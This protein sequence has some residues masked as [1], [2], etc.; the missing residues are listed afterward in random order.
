MADILNDAIDFTNLVPNGPRIN[1]TLRLQGNPSG[2]WIQRCVLKITMQLTRGPGALVP[3]DYRA[4]SEVMD[5]VRLLYSGHNIQISGRNL[6]IINSFR[7]AKL[8][9]SNRTL[10]GGDDS[11]VLYIPVEFTPILT[12]KGEKA[13]RVSTEELADAPIE[14]ELINPF[15]A[16]DVDVI[17][18][19]VEL[20]TD[21]A[22]RGSAE[23]IPGG[24]QLYDQTDFQG[25]VLNFNDEQL[26]TVLLGRRTSDNPSVIAN[27]GSIDG[28]GDG[29]YMY[30]NNDSTDLDEKYYEHVPF[31]PDEFR[32]VPG[33]PFLRNIPQVGEELQTDF[34]CV[35][36][37][38]SWKWGAKPFKFRFNSRDTT[39]AFPYI[40]SSWQ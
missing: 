1:R 36:D 14:I 9:G 23:K 24:L 15:P 34:T 13:F 40:V 37:Y 26:S 20:L 4:A 16:G 32:D 28:F 39:L 11:Y 22:E 38:R 3:Y 10:L 29:T 17:N 35:Y 31:Q 27:F 2:F 19:Q 8:N 33:N 7:Y 30:N 5:R 6:A 18:G 21:L 12:P 25:T